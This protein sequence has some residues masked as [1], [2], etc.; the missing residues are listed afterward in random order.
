ML[1]AKQTLSD[2]A[3]KL[4]T[5]NRRVHA[6]LA[7]AKE[8]LEAFSDPSKWTAAK[9]WAGIEAVCSGERFW[10]YGQQMAK[11]GVRSNAEIAWEFIRCEMEPVE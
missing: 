6:E 9:A 10:K 4:N 1:E 2:F 11:M 3:I 5:E 8:Q 7:A